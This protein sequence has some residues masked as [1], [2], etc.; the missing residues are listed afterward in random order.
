[1]VSL[2][3]DEYDACVRYKALDLHVT[4][5]QQNN[6]DQAGSSALTSNQA[7]HNAHSLGNWLLTG[8]LISAVSMQSSWGRGWGMEAKVEVRLRVEP[9]EGRE[10]GRVNMGLSM[11]GRG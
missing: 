7:H 2:T 5:V 1:M 8:S 10:G 11:E 4:G 3:D 6:R 9:G